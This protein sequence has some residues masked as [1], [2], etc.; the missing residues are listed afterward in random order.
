[1]PF[2]YWRSVEILPIRNIS[3]IRVPKPF[4]CAQHKPKSKTLTINIVKLL[5]QPPFQLPDIFFNIF[6]VWNGGN[7]FLLRFQK[8]V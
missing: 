7:L 5:P 6:P 2:K 8:C 3:R 1:M 4:D